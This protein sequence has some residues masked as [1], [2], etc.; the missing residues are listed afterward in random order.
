MTPPSRSAGRRALL[1]SVSATALLASTAALPTAARAGSFRSINQALA[2]G[3][4]LSAATSINTASAHAARQAS[5]G[6][7]N[8]AAAAARFRSLAQALAGMSY[9]G[10]PVPDGIAP[11]G[12][13][14]AQGVAGSNGTTLWSGA[15]SALTQSIAAGTTNVTVTQTAPV[16]SLTWQTY[17]IG[18]HTKLIYNQS[19]G[20]ALAGT[21]VAIN[22]IEDPLANPTTILGQISAPGKVFILNANGVL[23][24]A[25]SQLNVGSLVASTASIAAAQLT[26]D[27]NGLING[28]SLYGT[29][30]A[31]NI[32]TPTFTGASDTASIIVAPGATITATAPAGSGYVMLLADTVQNGGVIAT[33]HGQT[34]LAAGTGFQLQPGYSVSN[35]TATVIGSEIAVTN[36]PGTTL[37]VATNSGIV[38]ADQ[39][40]VTM[41]GHSVDQAGVILA[42]TT[43]NA[44]GTVHLLTDASDPT[45]SVNLAASS[46]TEILPEDDGSTALDSQRAANL[47]SSII[48]NGLRL[49]QKGPLNT[50]NTLADTLGESRIELSTGGSVAIAGGAMALAQGGQVA[51]GA[52]KSIA[53][54]SGATIDVSG[55]NAVLPASADSLLITGIVPYY[56][57]DSAAN[58]TGP[59][60]FGT[61]SIDL[62]T[63]TAQIA[64][65]GYTGN[66]Y[67][68][69]GLLE[70]SGNLALTPH[71]IE[72]WSALGG[73]VTLQSAAS[74]AGT[75]T[76]GTITVAAGSTINLTGGTVTY[77]AG[78]LAQSYV[79]AA[80]GEIFNINDAPGDLVY[81]G[82][83]KGEIAA[84]PRWSITQ[85]F[86]NP[87][88]TPAEIYQ[89]AYTIGRDSG[90]LTVASASGAIDGSIDAGVT[91]G[92]GQ[93]A[94]RPTGIIDP[95]LLS[96]SVAPIAGTLSEGVYLGG[97]QYGTATLGSLFSSNVLITGSLPL[98]IGV[99]GALPETVAG[100]I[101]ISADALNA[102][103]L[104]N[105]TIYT[106][107]GLALGAPLTVADGGHVTLGAPVIED[108]ASITAHGGAIA[109]TNLLPSLGSV[110][111]PIAQTPGTIALAAG[112]TLDASGAW[113]NLARNPG[114]A[115]AQGYAAGGT[116]TVAGTGPVDLAAGSVLDVSSGGV[117]SAAGKLTNEAGGSITVSADIVPLQSA[118]LDSAGAVSL[119]ADFRGYA[120]GNAGTLSLQAPV[121]LL[122]GGAP[123]Q[124]GTVVVADTLFASGFGD[125]VL[126][127]DAGLS[128]AAG[129]EIAITR[130][131][132]SL[133]NA[134]LPTGAEA[135]GAY[136]LL[137]P[138]LY[139]QQKGADAFAQRSG[140]SLVLQSSIDASLYNG[141]GGPVSIGAGASLGV[142]PGQSITLA[143][144]G[145]VT[146][147]GT[148]SAHGG[149]IGVFNTRFEQPVTDPSHGIASNV[150]DGLSVWIGDGAVLDVS[151]RAALMTDG[152][153]RRFGQSQAGGTILLGGE[154]GLDPN[155]AQSTYAQVIVRPGAVLDAQGASAAVEVVPGTE[156]APTPTAST[157]ATLLSGAGGTIEARSYFGVAL[158][159]TMLAGG[160]GAGAAGG[161]LD[162][163]LDPLTLNGFYG[164]PAVYYAPSQILVSQD[165]VAVQPGTGIAPGDPTVAAT[166]RLGRISQQQIDAGGFD[167]VSLY[168]QDQIVFDHSVDLSLGRSLVLSTTTIGDNDA[169]SAVTVHVPYLS[170]FGYSQGAQGGLDL[171]G[172]SSLSSLATASTLSLDADFIDVTNALTLGGIRVVGS[173]SAMMGGPVQGTFTAQSYGFATTL[174]DSA[175]DIRFDVTSDPAS[176]IITSI[177]STGDI[178][179]QGQQVYPATGAKALVTAGEQANPLP[180]TNPLA[181]G[182]LTILNQPGAAPQAP[183][184]V[185]GTLSLWADTI[186]QEGVLRAPEGA[187]DLGEQRGDGVIQPFTDAVVLAPGSVT[188]VSLYGQ[189][190]PY[191]GTV[192]GV[193]Y[194]FAG[195]PPLTFNPQ[196][197]VSSANI[198][199][200]SGAAIDLR[201]GGTLSGA[202]FIAGRGGS[203]DVNRVPLLQSGTGTLAA[204][205]A[206]Q[207]FAIVPGSQAQYAPVSPGDVGYAAPAQGEQITIRAGE[208][209]GL[210]AGTYTLLPAYYDL[211]P[212]AYR[213]ELTGAPMAR[214]SSG[215]FG[216]FTTEAAVTLGT[217]NTGIVAATPTEALITSGAGVR[218]LSQYN[219]ESYNAFEVAQAATFN[220]PRPLL[221]Q[222]AKTLVLSINTPAMVPADDMPVSIGAASLLQSAPAGGYGATMEITALNPLEIV[223]PGDAVVPVATVSARGSITIEPG[224]GLESGMLSALDVARLVIGGTLSASAVSPDVE[225]VRG[226]APALVVA[227]HADLTAGDI[228]LTA[229]GS[230]Q[231][232]VH[233]GAVLSTLGQPATAYGLAQGIYFNSDGVTQQ[234]GGSPVLSLSNVTV[235]FTPN[236]LTANGAAITIDAGA[237]LEAS[238]SLNFNA[239]Q[240]SSVQI[241]EASLHAA[242]ISVQVADINIGSTKALADFAGL[243]PQGLALDTVSLNTLAQGSAEL[244]LTANEAVNII[245]S[246]AL[247][248]GSTS[249]VLN[250]PAIYGYGIGMVTSAGSTSVTDPGVVS[251]TAPRFTWSGVAAPFLLQTGSNTTGSATPGGA[252]VGVA[253]TQTLTGAASLAIDAGTIVLGYG[254]SV[255]V[256]NQVVLDR[257]AVGFGA[258]SLAASGQITANNQSALSVFATQTTFGQAG[259]GGNLTLTSPL[260]TAASGAVLD[261]TAG[262]TL[263]AGGGTGTATGSIAT[264][265]ATIDLTA[266]TI[267]TST[268]F[269]LPSGKLVINAADGID[270]AA[271][272]SIDLAGRTVKLFDQTAY[273][274]GGTLVMAAGAAG[275]AEDVGAAIDV[276]SPGAAAGS[277]SAT[278]PT[279]AV[280]FDG[281]LSGSAA[282]GQNGGSFAVSALSLPA[283]D[284]LNASLDAGG[285]TMARHFE[286]ATGDITVDR[287]VTA[288]TVDI[289][290]DAG[291][292][293]VTGTI[294][295]SGSNPGSI[296]LS[297]GTTL[298]LGAPGVAA[299]L[300]AHA[301]HLAVDS[302]GNPI[303]AENTAHVSLTSLNDT[304]SSLSGSVALV[305]A[306][307]DVGNVGVAL[308]QIDIN[309][310]RASTG[311]TVN[312]VAVTIA[313]PLNVSSAATIT[314]NAFAAYSPTDAE[315]TIVQNNGTGNTQGQPY[316][317]YS[318]AGTLGIDQVGLDNATYM[319]FVDANGVGLAAQFA[320]LNGT[321]GVLH[322]RPGVL[323]ESSAASGGNLTISGDIDLSRLRTDD[324]GQFGL[325]HKMGVDGSGE[326]GA[327]VFRAANDLTINGSVTDG[328][329]RP[330]D[331]SGGPPLDADQNGWKYRQQ[332]YVGGEI[333]NADVL[334]PAGAVAVDGKQGV[335]SGQIVLVGSSSGGNAT[336]F[337]TTRPI[338]LNYAIV[339]QPAY[340]NANVVIPFAVTL[341]SAAPP[342][343]T[344]GWVATA[345]IMRNGMVLFARGQLIP[346]GFVFQVG[347]VLQSGSVMPVSV[348]TGVDA[349]G[350]GQTVPAGTPFSVFNDLNIY[351]AQ[352]TAV[353]P[354]NA[355]IP[356]N[357][358]AYF[359][360]VN[361]AGNTVGVGGIDLR[362][363]QKIVGRMVQGYLIP[364]APLLPAGSQSWSMDFVAGANLGGADLHA[365]Q[366]LAALDGG[367]FAPATGMTNQARGSILLDD[368][369]YYSNA[370]GIPSLAFSVIRTGTGALSLVAGGDIDQSSLYGIYTAGTQSLLPQGENAQFNVP[371]QH[372]GGHYLL[373]GEGKEIASTLIEQS[374]QA[375]YPN[376][377]GDVLF[378]AGGDVTGDLYGTTNNSQNGSGTP[379][380]DAIGNWLWRQ[381]STQLG[382][383][384]AWW[385]NFGTLADPLTAGGF[386]SGITIPVQMVGFQGIGALGGGNVTVDIGGDAGQMT[387]RDQGGN[388][389]QGA[390]Q[391]RGEGL[392]IAVGSTGRLLP[393]TTTPV[394]TGGG[395][396]SVT[397]GGTLNPLD[398]AAYGIGATSGST[399]F[400]TPAV[401]GDII[402]VRGN[403]VVAAG[404]IGRIDPIYS[405]ST[406]ILGDPRTL[407]PFTSEDG[408]PNG[409]IE[410]AP[411]DG[412]VAISTLRDLVLAGAADP[413]RVVEQSFTRLDAYRSALT[414]YADSGGDTG[415]TLWQADTSIA[416]F[417]NGGSVTPTTVPNTQPNAL[418]FANDAPTD[419][420]SIYPPN[421]FVTAA[422]GNIIYGQ[423]GVSSA[424]DA[425]IGTTTSGAESL[426][427]MPAPNGEVSFLAARSINANY[428]IVDISGADPLGLSRPTD[429]AFTS[430]V[431]KPGGLT[432]IVTTPLIDATTEELFAL[433]ADTP[434]T[435]LHAH[436]LT[437]A[438]FY[439]ATGD[440]L[441]FQTGETLSFVNSGIV[442]ATWYIAA[443]PVWIVAGQDIVSSGTRP[444]ADPN[445]AVFALQEN[446]SAYGVLPNGESEFSSGNLFF[447]T[448]A[449]A[450]SL[451]QAGRDILST[452]AYVGGP[453]LLQVQAGRNLYQASVLSAG[454][455]IL[456]FGSFKSLGNDLIA[457]SPISLSGGAGISVLAGVGAA[458]PDYTAFADLY[459]N[460]LNQANLALPL[461]DPSNAKKVQQVYAAPLAAWL[462]A[463]YGYTGN[464]DGALAAFLAL[465]AVDQGVFVRQ[466][467]FDELAASGAQESNPA[468]PFFGS[469]ARGRLAIDTLLPSNDHGIGA[470]VGYTGAITMYSGTVL[471]APTVSAVPLTTPTG[472][473]AI[474]DGGIATLFGGNVQVIDPGGEAIFGVPGGPAPG[475]SSGIVTYGSGSIDSYSLGSVLLGK[476]RIFT[477]AGGNILIWSSLGDI[478]AGIGAKT[479]QVYDPPVLVYDA[480]GDVTDTPP[481]VTTGAG[482]AT[483][484]PLPDVPAGNISLIAPQGTID[485]GEAGIRVSGNLVLAAARVTGAANIAVKGSTQGAPTVSVASLGAVEAAGAAAGAAQSAAQNQGTRGGES[486]QAASVLDVEVLSIGGTYDEERKRRRAM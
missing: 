93:T 82:L 406:V 117:L 120:T 340:L 63:V 227:A 416:L 121:F 350:T 448:G 382:Q 241:G 431:N 110:P 484:Q 253:G 202:A 105:I 89:P 95:F 286:A 92:E 219:E 167:A 3:P 438:R 155:S 355:L 141:G 455:Q 213:V 313:G 18:A 146:V 348:Q 472:A 327:I 433:E 280:N 127:G 421:L 11:G 347:D 477:T 260:I 339:I 252:L 201:G 159:G 200:Q 413:G 183:L 91:V 174:L 365:V 420:R 37:G 45:A 81:T 46:I 334:L 465:P 265:G 322:L 99:L 87:L 65:G 290:A 306:V 478:N 111:A 425:A 189:T 285:F 132:Y 401:N 150:Q 464:A 378:A 190:V 20:G 177:A 47:A 157:P 261:L 326:P 151:G 76:G 231:I 199:V 220:A 96:Q 58:R 379:A 398:A 408:V 53:L 218:Q 459:F 267:V 116:I 66:I 208:V 435:N 131:V 42:T 158:D 422:T 207:V 332:K 38:L 130:P 172:P 317:P 80:D 451:I 2:Q 266:G 196:V 182:T 446:Q 204:N 299:V 444:E 178:T 293:T 399:S 13:Q 475:N 396:I 60:E 124:A 211:L 230:G 331:E 311:G 209:A 305:D 97:A 198:D 354:V 98:P 233:T 468:S 206:D 136:T 156:T 400:E 50:A 163:R 229:S 165:G 257:L 304:N 329:S 52:G 404:A 109:L 139:T 85:T 309:A 119:D 454:G 410:V 29:I 234:E 338:S 154:G 270:L 236:A 216:N 73:Q 188:S 330:P 194:L 281:T 118:T 102:D 71:G 21:W 486:G 328:F 424:S 247:N 184:S 388:G 409:G 88:L 115:G 180:G 414:G 126:N 243:L 429:P 75:L 374:Y 187:I 283:F 445:S 44:R 387:D 469:Y 64:N 137:L 215:P 263:T 248:S 319:A 69:G 370:G 463:N 56:L 249:L 114:E 364:L 360:A 393:G 191:G 333:S 40:D 138:A 240:G 41:V 483:L 210:A 384:S 103:G 291:A 336:I 314:V 135:S 349:S 169:A 112:A 113:T 373:F 217:A 84:H 192:D 466:V 245:G 185:G 337:D 395:D 226:Q 7:Q 269:A 442:D 342:I 303:D 106:A 345:P 366:P 254:P 307:I 181:G 161:T 271:G 123:A 284:G 94:M 168:A 228:M 308:G 361:A 288:H 17:N 385:I 426:E 78:L 68:Q 405:A 23:F 133:A 34:I 440:I 256:D 26:T 335:V 9:T 471:N 28:F 237:T 443:K 251:I 125:Y 238:G 195:L 392:V 232:T 325:V 16:A 59:L 427:T 458:G 122:G 482:I 310:P 423:Y 351:L 432:N 179:L 391:Q 272:T 343:P 324:P 397:I 153:G 212:G 83:Y 128:V 54:A 239:P 441:D 320:A 27:T 246:V 222:D 221:P 62:R 134:L 30:A 480:L 162:M 166:L 107:G 418:V 430:A 100:T 224:F 402:D 255:Q 344:G 223:G 434:T 312:S 412:T 170:L 449:D 10:A 292:I 447:N 4:T 318:Q 6:A 24:G 346:A 381:G 225:D 152:L 323:I 203:A 61:A 149:T 470:P 140:A 19:A 176:S 367:V 77:Q 193:N 5:L 186:D 242:E 101:S 462:A 315:G 437:P 145:Q 148:L 452:Y 287:T 368:Q 86:A 363:T 214:G 341:G 142:D 15:A 383:P 282:S 164:L 262:G 457:G 461:T 289:A 55:T 279:G 273:S 474:F 302:Y 25:G 12:L 268:A 32:V 377:G 436:D 295:A 244:S 22:R 300:D 298:S 276:S 67:N 419:Y 476:S 160:A 479:T 353:L 407:D 403:I 31:G 473:N 104:A 294:N 205:T 43:V 359:G 259:T 57:R 274:S 380:S 357:T 144:Y 450:I 356:S 14:Q 70:L 74:N 197:V 90:S 390:F 456:D 485:A 372:N 35:P 173:P 175:G 51:V 376:G 8:V 371:R 258:V 362:P 301:T 33:P 250:T 369:H 1:H 171:N 352:D 48:D 439:A 49:T 415:F 129:A 389:A 143:G 108:E 375:N 296:G 39:G 297:A 321:A 147:L 411:G 79:Q 481:A 275:I 417:S 460:P 453:G 386:N 428:Y 358:D 264:L 467:Y 316:S 277:V 278:A 72:E 394:E 36:V 235:V